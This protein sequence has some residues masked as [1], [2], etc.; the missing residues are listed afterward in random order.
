MRKLLNKEDEIV[1]Y[2]YA[3]SLVECNI[4]TGI[5]IWKK[6]E[7]TEVSNYWKN[8]NTKYAGK[9]CGRVNQEGYR[10]ACITY[11]AKQM[12][13]SMHRLIWFA[14]YGCLPTNYIDHINQN[15]ADNRLVNLRDVTSAENNKN[16]KIT[17]NNSSGVVGVHFNKGK[18]K[19]RAVVT[20]NHKVHYLGYYKEI[21]EAEKVV[22]EFREKNGFTE[23]HGTQ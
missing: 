13:V 10:S 22:K 15:R 9:E 6:R 18:G 21:D 11:K 2:Q 19:W 20:V 4:E 17:S 12:Y 5:V 3:V 7:P 14:A 16:R 8:W 23:L 1:F